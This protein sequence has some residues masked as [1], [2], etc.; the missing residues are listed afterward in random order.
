MITWNE[1]LKKRLKT[2]SIK[3]V[4]LF[5]DDLKRPGIPYVVIKPMSGGDRKLYQIFVHN[6]VG[7]RD[8]LEEYILYELPNLLKEP[9]EVD[10]EKETIRSTGAWMGPYIDEGDNTL[11]MSRDYYIPLVV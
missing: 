2:G 10:G 7:T 9:L 1:E 8:L 5:G 11:A 3:N 4:V 6:K